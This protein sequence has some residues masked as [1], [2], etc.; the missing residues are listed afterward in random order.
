LSGSPFC[1]AAGSLYL[2]AGG[3]I[4]LSALEHSIVS[5]G[6]R[7]C[8][9]DARPQR[10]YVHTECLL[11][12]IGRACCLAVVSPH[13]QKVASTRRLIDTTE[14]IVIPLLLL[15]YG[16]TWKAG[17]IHGLIC[18]IPSDSIRLPLPSLHPCPRILA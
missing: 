16:N 5:R 17:W 8:F 6:T 4:D 2:A 3:N 18:L 7:R 9:L 12:H 1:W 13:W 11:V 10:C 15:P 14:V